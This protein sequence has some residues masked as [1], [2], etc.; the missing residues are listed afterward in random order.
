MKYPVFAVVAA[1]LLVACDGGNAVSGNELE[2]A[3]NVTEEVVVDEPDTDKNVQAL[4]DYS[5]KTCTPIDGINE[6]PCEISVDDE[7]G[8]SSKDEF[9][10]YYLVCMDERDS[11]E[12]AFCEEAA[13]QATDTTFTVE[14]IKS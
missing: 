10:G 7:R 5:V 13:R 8:Y 14:D 4:L 9:E 1:A 2:P 6:E 11:S 12:S 3:S